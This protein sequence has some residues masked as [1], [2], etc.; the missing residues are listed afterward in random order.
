MRRQVIKY[1]GKINNINHIVISDPTYEKDDGC[2]Y[3][4]ENLNEKNWLVEL[5]IYDVED[6]I[7]DYLIQG[8]EFYLLLQKTKDLCQIY[9]ENIKYLKNINIKKYDI[10][11]DTA[12]IALGINKNAEDIINSQPEW[13]PDC[14]IR[15]GTDGMFGLVT[16]GK[17]KEGL[18]FIVITGYLSSDMGYDKNSLFEYLVSKFEIKDLVK[19]EN[20]VADN[21]IDI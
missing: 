17:N 6:K 18:A 16:E 12:C 11:M 14:A 4:I 7:D 3:E 9:G 13:Q 19:E 1:K 8:I 5:N 21:D 15:T 10:G 2:R 20:K